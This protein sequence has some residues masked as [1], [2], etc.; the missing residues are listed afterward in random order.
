MKIVIWANVSFEKPYAS[1]HLIKEIITAS[2]KSCYEVYLVQPKTGTGEVPE[3]FSEYN[4]L[5]IINIPWKSVEKTNFI[6]RYLT[7]IKY[8]YTS[9]SEIKKTDGINSIFLQS[10][11]T[12]VFPVLMAKSAKLPIVY[13][14]QDIFPFDALAVG[15]L[16]K[17]SPAFFI[18]RFLQ[19]LAYKKAD[20]VV[21]ISD[22]LKKTIVAESKKDVEVVYNWSYRNE[23]YDIPDEQNHF[24]NTYNIKR[25]DG[26]RV[27][28]AGNIGK[29][30][31]ISMLTETALLLKDYKDIKFYIIG[32]G[33]NL[34]NLK[35]A[36]ES[37]NADNIVFYPSQPM[38]YAADNYCM[39]DVNINLVPKGVMFTCTP[40]KTN[41]CLLS[42]KPTVV[43]MD[44]E[45]DMA[46]RLSKVDKWT[47]VAPDD[48]KAMAE[49][50]LKYYKEIDWKSGETAKSGNSAEFIAKL[51]PV[52]N[53]YKYVKILE[54]TGINK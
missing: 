9:F 13:N 52:E 5:H 42:R 20:A 23:A 16:S 53:A 14:V 17:K 18:P 35:N 4:N 19:S 12:A 6:K 48:A 38:E 11:N 51:G 37:Q 30:M 32:E 2:L 7:A 33:S 39:A 31:N 15:M 34:Q 36:A 40:S 44:S 41:T 26:F 27:V 45:S 10:T 43:S 3:E 47:V 50:I 28:Y 49:G 54:R 24:L 46:Q 22:D 25:N 21:T 8:Y 1:Y 29:M